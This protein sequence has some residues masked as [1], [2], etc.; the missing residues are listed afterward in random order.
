MI[1]DRSLADAIWQRKP[2]KARRIEIAHD[3]NG[4]C[5]TVSGGLPFPNSTCVSEIAPGLA[6]A[7][8]A[9]DLSFKRALIVDRNRAGVAL[10][11]SA[12]WTPQPDARVFTGAT[13][14]N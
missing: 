3:D 14:R 11:Y 9:A 7:L 10:A 8:R 5:V 4:W 6:T 1:S 13:E 12:D 2:D